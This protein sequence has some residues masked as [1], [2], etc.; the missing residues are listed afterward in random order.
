MKLE[1]TAIKPADNSTCLHSDSFKVSIG[2]EKCNESVLVDQ[3]WEKLSSLES[4]Q[5]TPEQIKIPAV[6]ESEVLLQQLEHL[7]N[8]KD[9]IVI[10]NVVIQKENDKLQYLPKGATTSIN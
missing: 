2:K 3:L 1:K 7:N 9:V 5:K 4:D 8:K 10:S 6:V